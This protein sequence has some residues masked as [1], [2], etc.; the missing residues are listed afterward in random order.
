MQPGCWSALKLIPESSALQTDTLKSQKSAKEKCDCISAVIASNTSPSQCQP[1]QHR[2]C[3]KCHSVAQGSGGSEEQSGP[4]CHLSSQRAVGGEGQAE[5]KVP[6]RWRNPHL[7]RRR[8]QENQRSVLFLFFS[9]RWSVGLRGDEFT[10][11]P[12]AVWLNS[13]G[14]SYSMCVC[15]VGC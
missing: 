14:A 5:C 6:T 8:P 4:P 15:I 13:Y 1:L 11:K 3:L 9:L 7:T 2:V 12:V 10:L